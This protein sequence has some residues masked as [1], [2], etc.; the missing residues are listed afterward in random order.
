[1]VPIPSGRARPG[2]RRALTQDELVDA[3]L[4]LLDEGGTSAASIRRIAAEVGVAPNAVYTYFPDKAAMER[5]VVERLLGDVDHGA[6]SARNHP[7]RRRVEALA[8]DLRAN[9]AAH[10]GAV[11]L[12]M[13]GPMGGP[14]ALGLNEQLLE[15]LDDAGLGP[16]DAARAAY[17][18]VV[19]VLGS[20]ALNVADLRQPGPLPDERD[21]IS[22]RSRAL[23]ATPADAFPRTAAAADTIAG[24][25]TRDQ[26]LWGLG[27]LL[28]GISGP[29]AELPA[30]G[31]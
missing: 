18:L 6:F 7:W 15:L 14:H 20:L 27:R 9:L 13:G 17:L 23:A 30:D 22:M 10:P 1:M 21:R 4:K 26:F 16:Q 24:Y 11:P 12:F 25:V 8:L 2:P 29:D 28:D 19:F 5:A 3:A 31:S